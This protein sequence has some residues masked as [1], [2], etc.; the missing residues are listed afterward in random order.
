[1]ER[2]ELECE[3]CEISESINSCK[4]ETI[5]WSNHNQIKQMITQNCREKK[6]L[7]LTRRHQVEKRLANGVKLS[8]K[9]SALCCH[10]REEMELSHSP[11]LFLSL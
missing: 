8:L 4:E 1:M 9:K 2:I 10:G 7:Q 5:K 6:D 11:T 3:V